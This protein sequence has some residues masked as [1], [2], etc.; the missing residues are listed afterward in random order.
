MSADGQT[1]VGNLKGRVHGVN[2][3][4]AISGVSDTISGLRLLDQ[5]VQDNIVIEERYNLPDGNVA[6]LYRYNHFRAGLQPKSA[7]HAVK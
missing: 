5:L 6:S 7:I 4:V 1:I 3:M 2:S